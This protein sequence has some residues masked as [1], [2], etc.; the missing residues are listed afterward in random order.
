[1]LNWLFGLVIWVPVIPFMKGIVTKGG[2]PRISNHQSKGFHELISKKN[3]HPWTPKPWKMKVLN[4][5]HMGYN[6]PLKMKET[7]VIGMVKCCRG[8]VLNFGGGN[9]ST[10]APPKQN[11]QFVSGCRLAVWSSHPIQTFEPCLWGLLDF[12]LVAQVPREDRD[13]IVSAVV[14]LGL[15]GQP[16]T[17]GKVGSNPHPGCHWQI[18]WGGIPEPKD[19]SCH[20][21][22]DEESASWVGRGLDPG[23][24]GY[25][26]SCEETALDKKN[27]A[28]MKN[29]WSLFRHIWWSNG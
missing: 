4:P 12:G 5:P 20:P 3:H 25:S 24:G 22:G 17:R 8:Y 23:K 29:N 6:D 7:W 1:M 18:E 11:S 26:R 14:H 19:V 9:S 27:M 2:T 21:G 16:K 28:T 13:I 10:E 15:L